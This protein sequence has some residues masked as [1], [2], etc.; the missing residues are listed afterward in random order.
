MPARVLEIYGNNFWQCG[1]AAT[2]GE[3]VMI[4]NSPGDC[5]ALRARCVVC[6]AFEGGRRMSTAYFST[7]MLCLRLRELMST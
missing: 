4:C 6:S 5:V 3:D 7:A 1:F 2:R